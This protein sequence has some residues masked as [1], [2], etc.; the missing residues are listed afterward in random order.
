MGWPE[1]MQPYLEMMNDYLVDV[2][3]DRPIDR[4]VLDVSYQEIDDEAP[5]RRWWQAPST[6]RRAVDRYYDGVRDTLRAMFHTVKAMGPEVWVINGSPVMPDYPP[7]DDGFVA[8]AREQRRRLPFT[9]DGW[10][11]ES[12][13]KKDYPLIDALARI[14]TEIRP[15]T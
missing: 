7:T 10:D 11:V 13:E 1:P 2:L 14:V 4:F 9:P 3:H 12:W 8:S 5:R 6:H 15:Q